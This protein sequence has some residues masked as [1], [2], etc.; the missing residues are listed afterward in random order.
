MSETLERFVLNN[1]VASKL[2][3]RPLVAQ[4]DG[5]TFVF[6]H[7]YPMTLAGFYV[8]STKAIFGA[9]IHLAA[10]RWEELHAETL[11]LCR[12]L[13]VELRKG[14]EAFSVLSGIRTA[15]NWSKDTFDKNEILKWIDDVEEQLIRPD[16]Q[17]Q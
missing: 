14:R 8:I 9:S 3:N 1:A 10:R 2:A 17:P 4:H 5:K 11:L 15:M 7:G 6:V 12:G 16:P 13:N